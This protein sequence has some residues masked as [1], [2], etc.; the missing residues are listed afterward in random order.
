M[1]TCVSSTTYSVVYGAISSASIKLICT[2]YYTLLATVLSNAVYKLLASKS[3][4][5]T[6]INS[7]VWSWHGLAQTIAIITFSGLGKPQKNLP[8]LLVN[9]LGGHA[10][11]WIHA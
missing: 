4:K 1:Q 3:F 10:L 8:D 6:I 11:S 9:H 2:H 5:A 7:I